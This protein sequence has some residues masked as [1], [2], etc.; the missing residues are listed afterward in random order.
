MPGLS[1]F[2]V[3][4]L[5]F[6]LLVALLSTVLETHAEPQWIACFVSKFPNA[7][8]LVVHSA[9]DTCVDAARIEALEPDSKRAKKGEQPSEPN[10][11]QR[12]V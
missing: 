2:R 9:R 4:F 10:P 3:P 12:S 7:G 11:H 5:N 6:Q 1:G 8:C